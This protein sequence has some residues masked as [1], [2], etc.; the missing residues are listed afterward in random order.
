MSENKTNKQLQQQQQRT[1]IKWTGKTNVM[2]TQV[3]LETDWGEN[4]EKQ[5]GK[6]KGSV[7]DS[8][9]C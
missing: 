5:A 7:I 6:Y 9:M 8:A 2:R 4:L 1:P 3:R